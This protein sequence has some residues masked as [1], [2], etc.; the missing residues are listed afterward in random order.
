MKKPTVEAII[1]WTSTATLLIG[2]AL[3]SFN[4]YPLNLWICLI[5]NAGWA[6]VGILWKKWSLLLVQIVITVLYVAGIYKH[7][8]M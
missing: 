1:E 4:I 2:V 7:Y 3:T 6:L 5:A 8:M